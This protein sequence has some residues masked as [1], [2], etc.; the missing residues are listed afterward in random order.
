MAQLRT[1]FS[2]CPTWN[3]NWL[4]FP[5]QVHFHLKIINERN[6][7]KHFSIFFKHFSTELNCFKSHYILIHI[8]KK[9]HLVKWIQHKLSNCIFLCISLSFT[10][11]WTERNKKMRE[12][13]Q[14]LALNMA[15]NFIPVNYAQFVIAINSRTS[16]IYWLFFLFLFLL[17]AHFLS[18]V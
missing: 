11:I 17:R 16:I 8:K 15:L 5:F 18:M 6:C 4:C 12:V 13:T 9:L 2:S 3:Q 10:F 14:F 1:F 7:I